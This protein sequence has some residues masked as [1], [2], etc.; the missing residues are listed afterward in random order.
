M[1]AEFGPVGA[2]A[3]VEL[4]NGEVFAIDFVAAALHVVGVIGGVGDDEGG[5]FGDADAELAGAWLVVG[6]DKAVADAGAVGDV[7]DEF[8]APVGIG[9]ER[10]DDASFGGDG[11]ENFFRTRFELRQGVGVDAK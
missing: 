7:G 9:A 4:F 2:I 1:E 8:D 6:I 11:G 10:G 3:L 5:A